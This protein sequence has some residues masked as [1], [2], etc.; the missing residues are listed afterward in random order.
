LISEVNIKI[1]D[2]EDQK[3]MITGML[4]ESDE[5]V[6]KGRDDKGAKKEVREVCRWVLGVDLPPVDDY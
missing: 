1:S 4:W 3:A 2:G 6:V 5:G